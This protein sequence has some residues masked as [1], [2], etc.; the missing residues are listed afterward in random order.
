L[1]AFY[2]LGYGV[3]AFG[4]GPLHDHLGLPFA[5]IFAG[6]SIVALPL[7]VV[8]ALVIGRAPGGG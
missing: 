1:I 5:T 6:G 4:I 7:A 3:A 2:Q 8:A